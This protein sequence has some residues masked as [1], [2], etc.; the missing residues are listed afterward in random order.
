MRVLIVHPGASI[1]T[2]DVYNGLA[3]ALERAGTDLY[4]YNLD[5]RIAMSGGYLKYVTR[6]L[7][8]QGRDVVFSQADILYHAAQDL[9]ARALRIEAD[10]V[11]VVSGM[12]LH[13]DWMIMMRRAGI[14]LAVLLTE[15][16]YDDPHQA[17][18]LQHC[19][20]AWT[21]ERTS[22][23]FLRQFNPNV[24]YLPHAIDPAKHNP[25]SQQNM[26]P[27][28]KGHDV[29]FIGTAFIERQRILAGVN[30]DGVDLGL[31]GTYPYMGSRSKLRKYIKGAYVDNLVANEVYRRSKIGLN[32]YRT[33]MG[34][35]K[36]AKHVTD[37]ESVNP[38]ILELA[39]SGSF[40]ISDYRKEMHE[41]FGPHIPTFT[42]PRDL[43]D[44]IHYYLEN[45]HEREKIAETLPRI[46]Q[47]HEMTF[48]RRARQ[49]LD[50]LDALDTM[51]PGQRRLGV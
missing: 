10:W 12:Y 2:V 32:L 13:P 9:L 27:E 8:S 6:N 16:P 5:G 20:V 42:D 44:M 33:S 35:G 46:V 25:Y 30:W 41:I 45:D 21:N 37:A 22:V 24:N 48:D 34:F 23:P 17:Q 39:A 26:M 4:R 51:Y 49:V 38:R 1:S 14:R 3:G 43:Q 29:V 11:F 18:F 28:F 40:I 15:S 50:T 19:D 31:Y 36:D 7:K 47:Q